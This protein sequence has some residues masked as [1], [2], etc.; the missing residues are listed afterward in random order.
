[1]YARV[2]FGVLVIFTI[3]GAQAGWAAPVNL[4]W[5]PNTDTDLAGYKLYYGPTPRSQA[6]YPNVVV[7][8]KSAVTWQLT[9]S[10]GTYYFALTA[11]DT[12]GNESAFSAELST[13]VPIVQP[14]GKPGKPFLVP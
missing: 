7:I 4:A 5:D 8:S 11:F 1:M 14:L 13:V 12:S 3:V 9:L 10:S 6:T 2:L